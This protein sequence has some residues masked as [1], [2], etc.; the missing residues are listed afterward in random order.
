MNLLTRIAVPMLMFMPVLA[1]A[2]DADFSKLD[3]F[4]QAF[5]KFINGQLIP[6]IFALAFLVFIWGVFKYFIMGGDD[7]SAREKGKSLMLWGIIGF[8]VMVAVWGIVNIALDVL[9]LEGGQA[10]FELPQAPAGKGTP[11]S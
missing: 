10:D 1:Q 2:A 4:F 3:K 9:G 11:K 5:L 7:E 6:I 8:I